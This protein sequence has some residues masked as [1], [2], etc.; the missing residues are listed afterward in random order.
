MFSKKR[1]LEINWLVIYGDWLSYSKN[2]CYLKVHFT[3]RNDTHVS[4]RSCPCFSMVSVLLWEKAIGLVGICGAVFISYKPKCQSPGW[5]WLGFGGFPWN[6]LE[7]QMQFKWLQQ[8]CGFLFLIFFL[9]ENRIF[10]Y[11]LFWP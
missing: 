6:H 9:I 1:L 3:L 5:V 2:S 8:L 10:S 4:T 11:I 7:R